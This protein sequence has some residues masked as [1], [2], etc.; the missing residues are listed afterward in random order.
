MRDNA[1]GESRSSSVRECWEE[2][3]IEH[4]LWWGDAGEGPSKWEIHSRL[5]AVSGGIAMIDSSVNLTYR[6]GRLEGT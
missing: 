1:Q 3:I 2:P 4:G 6:E 5:D